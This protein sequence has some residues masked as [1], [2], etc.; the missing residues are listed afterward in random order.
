MDSINHQSVMILLLVG[1]I[2]L[3]IVSIHTYTF[4]C[5]IEIQPVSILDHNYHHRNSRICDSLCQS[6]LYQPDFRGRPSPGV[7]INPYLSHSS[8]PMNHSARQ[9]SKHSSKKKQLYN[10]NFDDINRT[11]SSVY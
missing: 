6:S 4:K 1:E 9:P 10:M 2:I 7:T 5:S 8:P 3:K 11:Y